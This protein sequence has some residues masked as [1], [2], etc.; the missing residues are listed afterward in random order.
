MLVWIGV[1]LLLVAVGGGALWIRGGRGAAGAVSAGPPCPSGVDRLAGVWDPLVKLAVT[2][3]FAASDKQFVRDYGR[4]AYNI[5]D[6]VTADL[7]HAQDAYCREG[8]TADPLLHAQRGDCIDERLRQL[9]REAGQWLTED[10][11][12]LALVVAERILNVRECLNDD[13]VRAQVPPLR[14]PAARAAE[15]AAL[16]ALDAAAGGPGTEASDLDAREARIDA[17][18]HTLEELKAPSVLRGKLVHALFVRFGRRD[19]ER[20]TTLLDAVVSQADRSRDD[21]VLADAL[22]SQIGAHL[23]D[24]TEE[25]RTAYRADLVETL[26]DRQAVAVER[27]G[28]RQDAVS[29]L[30]LD[31]STHAWQ[32]GK[33]DDSVR[34]ADELIA[35]TDKS[36]GP[37]SAEMVGARM[38]RAAY[39]SRVGD[40]PRMLEET[41]RAMDIRATLVGARHPA[42]LN[43]SYLSA[44]HRNNRL[45]EAISLAVAR[46]PTFEDAFGA[47]SPA[48][49]SNMDWLGHLLAA[50]GRIDES[51]STYR[52]LLARFEPIMPNNPTM[53]WQHF[54]LADSLQTRGRA[55]E[56]LGQVLESEAIHARTLGVDH[57]ENVRGPRPL[58][59]GM[60]Y[61]LGRFDEARTRLTAL[62]AILSQD[63]L[64]PG[65]RAAL[66]D[67]LEPVRVML[68]ARAG[69]RAG[70]ERRLRAKLAAC[71]SPGGEDCRLTWG[72]PLAE[73]LGLAG[74]HREAA[75]IL[76]PVHEE[77]RKLFANQPGNVRFARGF[78]AMT[79][80]LAQA[81]LLAG[82]ATAAR[83]LL[84]PIESSVNA[85]TGDVY[86]PDIHFVLARA[87]VATGGDHAHAVE[88]ARTAATELAALGEGR[89]SDARDVA[90]WLAAHAK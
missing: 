59:I 18:L 46:M 51:I 48:V 44:L 62:D 49:M 54:K 39:A 12:K 78:H 66:R 89:A 1:P 36:F 90:R 19:F 16:S 25:A 53:G 2:S 41:R 57:A 4:V 55:I 34:L 11:S 72:P 61:D 52:V 65:L 32:I 71:A 29:Q 27:A 31:R 9:K 33:R 23:Q 85:F 14:D 63:K 35:F 76:T 88:L 70:A 45:D 56:A 21:N 37:D 10:V 13:I 28:N 22:H 42:T 82:D 80:Q 40:F 58:H 60:L 77:M 5:T 15:A 47:S 83:A 30:M 17:V 43:D 81:T 68:A 67:Q 3:R 6:K 79:T 73:L 75:A 74:R 87:L 8:A 24:V 7:W 50:A 38:V 69:D 20:G 86:L 84:E 64:E 26:L